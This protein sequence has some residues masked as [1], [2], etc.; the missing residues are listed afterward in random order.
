MYWATI[1]R[2]TLLV[3]VPEVPVDLIRKVPAAVPELEP[4]I[5]VASALVLSQWLSLD[6]AVVAAIGVTV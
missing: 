5:I 1:V 4:S 6:G 2:E 3:P